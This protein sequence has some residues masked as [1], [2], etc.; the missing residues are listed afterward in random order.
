MRYCC[1]RFCFCC[2]CWFNTFIFPHSL[3]KCLSGIVSTSI[4][5]SADIIII[6]ICFHSEF[7]VVGFLLH[8]TSTFF[9]HDSSMWRYTSILPHNATLFLAC[10]TLWLITLARRTSNAIILCVPIRIRY[11]IAWRH[12]LTD[13]TNFTAVVDKFRPINK[14]CWVLGWIFN[15]GL[16]QMYMRGVLQKFHITCAMYVMKLFSIIHPQKNKVPLKI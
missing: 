8:F 6:I 3:R 4:T 9:N 12:L 16:L 5:A 11:V 15:H 10:N 1:C 2:W 7:M 13:D 14:L